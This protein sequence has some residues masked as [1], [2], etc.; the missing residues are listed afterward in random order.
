MKRKT[1]I[2][3]AALAVGTIAISAMW[4][5]LSSR[6][7]GP[8]PEYVP[9]E[10]RMQWYAQK[11]RAAGRDEIEMPAPNIDYGGSSPSTNLDAAL[12]AYSV[13]VAQPIQE[14]TIAGSDQIVTW[15]RFK[16][17]R[18]L[19]KQPFPAC[20]GCEPVVAPPAMT[21]QNE[22]EFVAAKLGGTTSIDGVKVSM[23]TSSPR[24]NLG[25][26]YLLFIS[27]Y[28]TG[29]AEIGAGPNGIFVV[30]NTESIR[31]LK[32]SQHPI[33]RDIETKVGGLSGLLAYIQKREL[34]L[35]K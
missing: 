27:R 8:G 35:S 22:D 23:A 19:V 26:T 24:L 18:W 31:P 20:K 6:A 11:A 14:Q 7:Q 16:V 10:N 29:G 25:A 13:V 33:Q 21:V 2:I 4:L 5:R 34:T 17:L 32:R 1:I 30:D 3:V 28:S 9:P 15:Y 12:A